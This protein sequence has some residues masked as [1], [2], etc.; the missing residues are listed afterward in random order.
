MKIR[1][2]INGLLLAATLIILV[3]A[4]M[5]FFWVREVEQ[6]T[7]DINAAE[8]LIHSATQL[9]QVAVETAL[10]HEARTQDQWLR[11]IASITLEI[12]RMRT[13]TPLEKENLE[14]IRK[15]IKLMQIIYPRL[16]G[17]PSAATERSIHP[18]SELEVAMQTRAVASLLVVTRGIIDI[19][20]ELIRGNREQAA[21]AYARLAVVDWAG[22]SGNGRAD[23]FCLDSGQPSHP[24]AFAHF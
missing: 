13:T 22:N 8:D 3:A 19:E 18:R 16:I 6:A 7:S 15:K 5:T 4:A 11:K 17:S 12:D 10:F 24:A 14:R 23:R 2:Q 20:N 1:S 9:N 21:A